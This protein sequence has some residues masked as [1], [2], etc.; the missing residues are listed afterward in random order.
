[1]TEQQGKNAVKITVTYEDGTTQEVEKGLV[2]SL[3]E[4]TESDRV[5]ITADMVSISGKDLYTI[6]QA[7]VE[8][9]MRLGMFG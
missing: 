4:M 1:M 7:A 2:W 9:G 6:V 8:L 5:E 3:T